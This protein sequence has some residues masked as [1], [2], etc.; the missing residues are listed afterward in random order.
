MRRTMVSLAVLAAM[1]I[2][3][4]SAADMAVKAQPAPY[5]AAAYNWTGLYVGGQVG[6]AW[7]TEQTTNV[8]ATTSTPPGFIDNPTDL[9]GLLGGFYGG[10][11]YQ[12]NQY[13]VGVDADYSWAGVSGKSTDIGPLNGHTLTH[14][15]SLQWLTTV[16]GRLGYTYDSLLLFV[17]G[18]GAWAQFD[19]DTINT[20]AGGAFAGVGSSS[21]V[22]SGWTV[23]GGVEYGVTPHISLKL[24]Y[25]YVDF[26]TAGYNST[27]ISSTGVVATPTKSSTSSINI[28]RGGIAYRF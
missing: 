11:N 27:D 12:F 25:D 24:E 3:V 16:T 2:G 21:D 20:T 28:L 18:G 19:G 4:A 1:P 15:P 14:S 10:Y 22:R 26:A 6:W 9:S 13:L 5:T 7:G 17:K 8:T 23:G